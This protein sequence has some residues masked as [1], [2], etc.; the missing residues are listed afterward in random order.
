MADGA[1][2]TVHV[3]LLPGEALNLDLFHTGFKYGSDTSW[4]FSCEDEV[5]YGYATEDSESAYFPTGAM[6]LTY[7]AA[8]ADTVHK[9]GSTSIFFPAGVY[10]ELPS[11]SGTIAAYAD[12]TLEF[13]LNFAS[14]ANDTSV[15][16]GSGVYIYERNGI[17]YTPPGVS[18]AMSTATW[19]HVAVCRKANVIRYFL[20]GVKFAEGVSTAALSITQFGAVAV[21]GSF[22]IDS[23]GFSSHYGH[24]DGSGFIAPILPFYNPPSSSGVRMTVICAFTPAE[25]SGS[26]ITPAEADGQWAR[27]VL[28]LSGGGTVGSKAIVDAKGRLIYNQADTVYT[29]A[30]KKFAPTSLYFNGTSAKLAMVA[31]RNLDLVDGDFTIEFWIYPTRIQT[32]ALMAKW[33]GNG[34]SARSYALYMTAEGVISFKFYDGPSNT[35]TTILSTEALSVNT[36]SFVAVCR[37]GDDYRVFVNGS[38]GPVVTTTKTPYRY[39]SR[40]YGDSTTWDT[41]VVIGAGSADGSGPGEYFQGYLEDFRVTNGFA[42]YTTDPHA[43]PSTAF[44][45]R[46]SGS[47]GDPYWGQVALLCHFDE[48]NGA[49]SNLRDAKGHPLYASG[50]YVTSFG[51][52]GGSFYDGGG[53]LRTPYGAEFDLSMGDFTIELWGAELATGVVAGNS[54]NQGSKGW[55]ISVDKNDADPANER[56]RGYLKWTQWDENGVQDIAISTL[57]PFYHD[58]VY[59]GAKRWWHIAVVRKDYDVTLFVDGVGATTAIPRLPAYSEADV[60]LCSY[61]GSRGFGYID[62]LRFT[63][64]ARYPST[65]YKVPAGKLPETAFSYGAAVSTIVHSFIPASAKSAVT[66]DG[67]VASFVHSVI[68]PLIIGQPSAYGPTMEHAYSLVAPTITGGEGIPE[69]VAFSVAI[70]TRQAHSH[71]QVFYV[72]DTVVAQAAKGVS[73]RF[74]ITDTA[75]AAMYS[76]GL[77]DGIQVGESAPLVTYKTRAL[78]EAIDFADSTP[79]GVVGVVIAVELA[80]SDAPAPAFHK[81]LTQTLAA[82][83]TAHTRQ[84][85]GATDSIGVSAA[86]AYAG[87]KT[88][89]DGVAFTSTVARRAGFVTTLAE[90]VE[91]SDAPATDVLLYATVSEDVAL[92]DAPAQT[93]LFQ[94]IVREHVQLKTFFAS[95]AYTTWAMNTRNA[96]VTQYTGYNFNSFAKMGERYMGANDQGLYWLDGDD[97]AGR[98]I[99]SRI[100]TGVIQP[101]GNKLSGVQYAYLG[102]R[103]DGEFIVTVTDEA[104]GSYN[105]TLT[106]SSMETS[107]VAFGRGFKTRYFTFSL[108]S[109]GQDFD[110]DSAEFVTTEMARKVQ[111]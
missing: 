5:G 17:L 106:G 80:V 53:T 98:D 51:L 86:P 11:G 77:T 26:R 54:Y 15:I 46:G 111:R 69:D 75:S 93:L 16:D 48:P 33:N 2:V 97:D 87:H 84:T 12:F 22:Y 28:L 62:E 72:D 50:G 59:G 105:Y 44:L 108:E 55:Q 64:A 18:P 20:N 70:N 71:A 109:Q 10:Q 38:S 4:S 88:A 7:G 31:A 24:Y 29:D 104:G 19:Y 61:P 66:I 107:R 47:D 76:V 49:V 35:D 68:P 100:T 96:A 60:Y 8:N 91:V 99:K 21:R 36:F 6:F 83:D 103:G 57:Y 23:V 13:F 34:V 95:P 90:T 30:H 52:Y 41:H 56:L 92:A 3:V 1:V 73:I 39:T 110:L 58:N 32:S 67:V 81:L 42:R 79:V 89:S 78:G 9:F 74:G 27:T 82:S 45:P 63:R 85:T 14:M 43:V 25:A 102:M 65:G 37:Y 94:A 40:T 101:N